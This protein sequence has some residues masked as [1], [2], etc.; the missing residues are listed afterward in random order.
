M[1][2]CPQLHLVLQSWKQDTNRRL[3]HVT[4]HVYLISFLSTRHKHAVNTQQRESIE[5]S[6]NSRTR[7]TMTII[8]STHLQ[9]QLESLPPQSPSF[10]GCVCL[11]SFPLTL[12]RCMHIAYIKDLKPR[13]RLS[14]VVLYCTHFT[15]C[16]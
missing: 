7:V 1:S 5:I 6:I 11:S 15:A 13:G 4:Q 3:L 10:A 16:T 2:N 14:V 8:R 9:C 12:H